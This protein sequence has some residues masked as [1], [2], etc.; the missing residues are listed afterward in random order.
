M[1]DYTFK[2]KNA[3]KFISKGDKVKFTIKF[4]GREMQHANLRK[5]IDGENKNGYA[6]NWQSGISSESSM[7]NK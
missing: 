7:A 3:Q 4:K 6:I 2:I 1:H 5:S